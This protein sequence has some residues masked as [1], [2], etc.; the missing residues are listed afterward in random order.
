AMA[1]QMEQRLLDLLELARQGHIVRP[2]VPV[3]FADLVHE[4]V[5][6]LGDRLRGGGIAV[7]IAP[8]MP[9]V[10]GDPGRLREV[11]ENLLDNACKYMGGQPEPRIVIG[12]RAGGP[13]PV[14]FVQDNGCGIAPENLERVFDL[15][16]QLQPG[17][18][19]AGAGLAIVRRIVEATGGQVWAES[20]GLG[21]GS[22]IC[23]SLPQVTGQV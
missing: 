14:F 8:G 16:C 2:A 4:V 5:T 10:L 3:P 17:G 18:S 7:E 11:L 6:A 12:V 21:K 15:F 22:S 13:K 1:R 9:A 20:A 23:F 19:G